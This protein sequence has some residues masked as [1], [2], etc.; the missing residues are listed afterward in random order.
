M[1]LLAVGMT[2]CV[3]HEVEKIEVNKPE[4]LI[5]QEEIDSYAPLKS[6]I[7]REKN[8]DFK[9]GAGASL[10]DYI[11]KGVTY[12]LLNRNFDEITLGY[13][14]KHGAVILDD[15]T[16][17][18]GEVE[19]LLKDAEAA[20][21]T[22]FGHTLAWHANQNAKYLNNAIAATVIPSTGGPALEDNLFTTSDFEDG[23][24]AW[25]GWGGSSSRGLS[26]DG[27][28]YGGSGYAFT[29]TNPSATTHNYEVQIAYDFP[30]ALQEGSTY[31]LTFQVKG[32]E[33]GSM[34]ASFQNPDGWQGRGNFETIV[35]TQE[36]K[37]ITVKAN[38]T[39]DNAIR[40][41]FDHGH[42][43]GTIYIDDISIRRENPSGGGS[44]G[45]SPIA[46]FDADDLGESYPMTNGGSGTVVDDPQGGGSKVLNIQGVQTFPQFEVTLPPG[47]TLGNCVSVSLDFLGTGSTGMYGQGMRMSINGGPLANYNSPANFGATDG[48]WARGVIKLDISGLDLTEEQK[49]L[50]SFT[51]AV[52]SATGSADYYIDNVAMNWAISGDIII[53]K[54]P[55]EKKQIIAEELERWIAGMLEVSKDYVKAWDVLNEPMDD[56]NPYELKTGVGRDL[57]AD[58]FYWQDYLGKDYVVDAFRLAREYGNPDDIHFINDYNLEYNLDKCKGIIQL[59]E[60]IEDKGETVHGIGTQ[61]HIDINSDKEKIAEMFELLAATGKLIKISELDIGLGGVSTNDATEEQYQAQADMY[62]YVVEKYF[63]IIPPSQRYGITIWS[64][65]D[66]PAGSFW[67]AGEPIGL[68]TEGLVRKPAYTAVAD[69]LEEAQ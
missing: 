41:L 44:A 2:S 37:E 15:G 32:T 59:V 6:Y 8:P 39:G 1:V 63:E 24:G 66:S 69:G 43:V 14:M 23:Q 38:V 46:D 36:W 10:S 19:D 57:A 5:L 56:G 58:E 21:M 31:V 42:Y 26:A 49:G 29:A 65:T 55:E 35:I 3:D 27:E 45:I 48:N 17:L 54:T 47:V 9:L 60:Y 40:F 13:K 51:L 50:N 18:T 62:K 33:D 4:S 20:G 53:E 67:R 12:R 52:G 68:W 64:P 11:S 61:M 7:D 28:G 16:F 34:T 30:V 25:G 22:V